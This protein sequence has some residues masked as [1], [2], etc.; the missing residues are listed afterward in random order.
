[1]TLEGQTPSKKAGIEVKRKN[2]ENE[3]WVG[4]HNQLTRD[5]LYLCLIT[6]FVQQQQ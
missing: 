3:A 4:S 5:I 6:V 2:K 1:M